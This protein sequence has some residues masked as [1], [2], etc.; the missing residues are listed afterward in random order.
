MFQ[1]T[2]GELPGCPLPVSD[3][4][5]SYRTP[6][7]NSMLQGSLCAR[8]LGA[9]FL[10]GAKAQGNAKCLEQ[11]ARYVR[12]HSFVAKQWS[13][14]A[15]RVEDDVAEPEHHCQGVPEARILA[16]PLHC[17][18]MNAVSIERLEEQRA[19]ALCIVANTPEV[20]FELRQERGK[21]LAHSLAWNAGGS[22]I[23]KA[24]E[25]N[26]TGHVECEHWTHFG[27]RKQLLGFRG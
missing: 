3:C 19:K 1:G 26:Y 24:L 23:L 13:R 14:C 6:R 22:L 8:E 21:S 18:L 4:N 2:R 9:V 20:R 10:A 16:G 25:E 7:F 17:D 15:G 11:S 27:H 12:F 5:I